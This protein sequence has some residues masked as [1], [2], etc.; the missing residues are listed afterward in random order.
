MTADTKLPAKIAKRRPRAHAKTMQPCVAL[1]RVDVVEVRHQATPQESKGLR[2]RG[3]L[4]DVSRHLFPVTTVA[5]PRSELE[6]EDKLKE[7]L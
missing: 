7:E 1:P 2:T 4:L 5:S 6:T 3:S